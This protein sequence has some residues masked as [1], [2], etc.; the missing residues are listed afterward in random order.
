ML[1]TAAFSLA[2]R[3]C[4]FAISSFRAGGAFGT[5]AFSLAV[6]TDLVT[7]F[8]GKSATLHVFSFL[9]TIANAVVVLVDEFTLLSLRGLSGL[10][11]LR[12]GGFGGCLSRD[13]HACQG[14]AQD[15][16][17]KNNY[18]FHGY[19]CWFYNEFYSKTIAAEKTCGEILYFC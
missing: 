18:F 12:S 16:A 4:T 14:E 6:V 13:R 5:G 3:T 8:V 19:E 9:M 1:T 15:K 2:V 17:C 10:L 7:V 11:F